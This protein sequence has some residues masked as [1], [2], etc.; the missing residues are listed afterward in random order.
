MTA[1]PASL[2]A[3]YSRCCTSS[4]PPPPPAS[5]HPRRWLSGISWTGSFRSHRSTQAPMRVGVVQLHPAAKLPRMQF[6]LSPAAHLRSLTCGWCLSTLHLSFQERRRCLIVGRSNAPGLSRRQRSPPQPAACRHCW[7]RTS[8][9]PAPPLAWRTSGRDPWQ[10]AVDVRHCLRVLVVEQGVSPGPGADAKPRVLGCTSTFHDEQTTAQALLLRETA[11]RPV[12]AD[13][14]D[15]MWEMKAI[16]VDMSTERDMQDIAFG[17]QLQPECYASAG[18]LNSVRT[19]STELRPHARRQNDPSTKSKSVHAMHAANLLCSR[20]RLLRAL[21]AIHRH[22]VVP[23]FVISASS[24]RG[25]ILSAARQHH[26][27]PAAPAM[28]HALQPAGGAAAGSAVY[29]VGGT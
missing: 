16:D 15:W 4:A 28:P 2:A 20:R 22:F 8:G 24:A 26:A 6:A 13:L 17:D 9:R 5:D 3:A 7:S 18:G 27:L 23:H 1:D 12:C 21:N 19:L 29:N 11:P 14:P 10:V 25:T